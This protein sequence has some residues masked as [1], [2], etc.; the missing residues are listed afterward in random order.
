MLNFMQKQVRL[1]LLA[2]VALIAAMAFAPVSAQAADL[3][4]DG[5]TITFKG[6]TIVTYDEDGS[7]VYSPTG[8]AHYDGVALEMLL[9][10]NK[11]KTLIFPKGTKLKV[12]Q[13][14]SLGNN[15][16]IIATGATI[17]Q[18]T[19]GRGI[20]ENDIDGAKYNAV[21]NVSITGGTW[22]NAKNT[23]EC[24]MFRFAHAA[25]L[26]FTKV[27]I[28]TN[29]KGHALELIACKNVVVDS[30][31]LKA[32]NASTKSSTSVEEALQ[33]DIATPITAPGVYAAT[34]NN[35]YVN[36][37]TCTNITVTNCTIYGSRGVCANYASKETKFQGK[38][39]TNVTIEGCT[40]TGTSAEALVLFNTV[41]WT[42]KNNTIKTLSSRTS[43]PYSDGFHATLFKANSKASSYKNVLSGN[44]IYG[45]YWGVSIGS[46]CSSNYGA[47]T[48]TK[49]KVYVR[50]TSRAFYL[51][52]CK[53]LKNT[54]NKTYTWK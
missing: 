41:G 51:K 37:Q 44:T 53:S 19:D 9:N 25:N 17:T 21:K 23:K 35:K 22:K 43:T 54:K 14:I 2:V 39:H 20:F 5:E 30:C 28:F 50:S 18:T 16:T 4:D 40:I 36:G 49:N 15:T 31:N 13:V 45:T 27:K 29:F 47:T 8:N 12:D 10:T 38:Y 11:K 7:M 48:V 6:Y 32:T 24:T 46:Q 42:V 26:T 33:I 1:G 52:N 34:K 3:I